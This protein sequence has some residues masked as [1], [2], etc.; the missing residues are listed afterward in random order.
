MRLLLSVRFVGL[1]PCANCFVSFRFVMCIEFSFFIFQFDC[2]CL[3]IR[4]IIICLFTRNF[5]ASLF[6]GDL[7]NVLNFF[8]VDGIYSCGSSFFRVWCGVCVCQFYYYIKIIL[9]IFNYKYVIEFRWLHDIE[10]KQ[11]LK[12]YT[13]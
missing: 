13:K 2:P 6:A 8:F 4:T 11:N 10:T 5:S 12:W 7:V 1:V 3:N 9:Y